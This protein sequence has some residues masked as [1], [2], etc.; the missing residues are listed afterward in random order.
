MVKI[1]VLKN[2]IM[3][4]YY[5]KSEKFGEVVTAINRALP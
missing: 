3:S 4:M 5:I 1:K 2:G